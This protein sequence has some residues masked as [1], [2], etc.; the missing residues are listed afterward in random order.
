MPDD[1]DRGLYEKYTVKRTDGRS[2]PGQKHEHCRY[3]VLDLTHDEFARAAI[4]AYIEACKAK[5]PDLAADLQHVFCSGSPYFDG[6][7]CR[8]EVR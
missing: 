5:Y 4:E 3:F 8:K 6:H 1:R 7:Q 2:E